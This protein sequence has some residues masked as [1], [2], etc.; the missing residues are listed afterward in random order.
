MKRKFNIQF[1]Y[2]P[3]GPGSGWTSI[4]S[5]NDEM[6]E[7]QDVTI[8]VLRHMVL[9]MGQLGFTPEE[10]MDKIT[11]FLVQMTDNMDDDED[12]SEEEIKE[13]E[14]AMKS[15]AALK[16]ALVDMRNDPKKEKVMR[17]SDVK[18]FQEQVAGNSA[19]AK[20][21]FKIFIEHLEG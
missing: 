17:E 8:E 14:D 15:V 9:L 16:D 20:K 2:E 10:V 12:L 7:G 19:F 18:A 11:D 3:F 5:G 13:Y 4:N 21:V 6:Q 1:Q